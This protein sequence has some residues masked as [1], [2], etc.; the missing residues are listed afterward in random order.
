LEE[1]KGIPKEAM[2]IVRTDV[3]SIEK[4]KE[5]YESKCSFCHDPYGTETIVGPSQMV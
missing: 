1:K 5:L 4:G 2:I 3:K